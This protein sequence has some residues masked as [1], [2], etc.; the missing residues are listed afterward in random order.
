[1][2]A[3]EPLF[4][5][6]DYR[7]FLADWFEQKKLSNRHFSLRM[8]AEQ[9]GFKARDYLMRVMRG[10]RNL[11]DEGIRKLSDFFR[12]SE[13][14]SEYFSAL[15]RLNQARTHTDK[16]RHYARL[17]E[18]RKYGSHQRLRQDQFEYLTAWYHSALRSLL[19]VLG[20]L[21]QADGREDWERLGKLLDPPLTA[22]QT[23]DS[24]ELL[25]RLGLLARDA[26]GRYAVQ[27]PA[28]T[29][30]DEV[31]ALG[32]AS[33][34]RATMELAKRSIDKHPP[35]A[36][37]ISGVTMSISQEGFRRIKSELRAFRKRIQAIASADSGEDMVYQLNLH[38]FPLTR[39][40]GKA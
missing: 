1:M 12:F 20:P 22:K 7:Q 19:P 13:K 2:P 16:E 37:D 21:P 15:V 14:Q 27:E 35:P 40:R 4:A 31:T 33:F 38:L 24:A 5:Y 30:G 34:H 18:V 17:A 8:L 9:S 29:T 6:T 11:S 39:T 10:E 36:R 23:R 3:Q 25:L 32:V 26:Q 28:L